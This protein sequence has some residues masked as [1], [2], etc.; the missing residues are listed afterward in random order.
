MPDDT[1]SKSGIDP[2]FTA[3][4]HACQ[5]GEA[6]DT[7]PH[8]ETSERHRAAWFSGWDLEHEFPLVR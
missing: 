8:P 2:A 6:R 4:S 1:S 3:S 5:R 7:N